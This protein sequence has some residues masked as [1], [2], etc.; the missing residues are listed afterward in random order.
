MAASSNAHL[1]HVPPTTELQDLYGYELV[2]RLGRGGMAEI[3]LA[4]RPGAYGAEL[5]VVKRLHEEDADDEVIL[6]MFVDES[7]LS[8]LLRHPNIVRADALGLIQGRH[9]LVLEFLEGQPLQ[10]FLKRCAASGRELPLELV[11]SALADVLDGLHYAHELTDGGRPLNVVHRDVSPHNLFVT[12]TGNVKLLDFG[13]A[14]TQIQENR[15]RTGLLKG[16]VAYMAPEQAHGSRVDRRA[17]IWSAGVTLW[18]AV[19]GARL[20]KADNEAASLRLTLTGAIARPS[21]VR[22]DVPAELDQIILRA[23]RR[24]PEDRYPTAAALAGEL[25]AWG[26]KRGMPLAA[27]FKDLMAELCGRELAEQRLRI[28]ALVAASDGL[29]PSSSMPVLSTSAPISSGRRVIIADAGDRAIVGGTTS[30]A[31]TLTH[32]ASVSDFVD[33]LHRRQRTTFRWMF[34]ALS[35]LALAVGGLGIA[36]AT[37][38]HGAGVP[39]T[40]TMTTAELQGTR[41]AVPATPAVAARASAVAPITTAA[42]LP[43]NDTLATRSGLK[44]RG[45][46]PAAPSAP[47]LPRSS[48]TGSSGNEPNATPLLNPSPEFG[49]LTLDTTPW[50]QVTVD[51]RP[52]GQTPVLHAKLPAGTHLLRLT[53]SERGL[54]TTYPI[55]IEPGQTS[56]RR[57]GLD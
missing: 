35:A 27:P 22:A 28:Q 10:T 11:A 47:A 29:P 26:E 33:Q 43:R 45:E 24:D 39:L 17:D 31:A 40:S 18:E 8:L 46:R 9:A 41:G 21:A 55:T 14:K 44:H 15:T 19:T 3:M 13:I 36:L 57:L 48:V 56:V 34:A 50:S 16:K 25:R 30:D 6:G 53:N 2:A 4:S 5:V 23:L 20:F 37:R 38:V 54:A 32:V 52:L 51:G 1:A 42:P 12:T 7:R 49:Y